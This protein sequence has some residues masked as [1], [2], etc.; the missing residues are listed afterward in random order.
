MPLLLL[1]NL[2]VMKY[3]FKPLT[4]QNRGNHKF[5]IDPLIGASVISGVGSLIGG[6]F[7]SSSTD[8]TNRANLTAVRET[9]ASNREIAEKTN[10]SN[11]EIARTTNEANIKMNQDN[12]ALQQRLQAE[13][14]Q[15][16]SVGAQLDRAR[17][18]GVNP[19]AVI[20]GSLSGNIQTSLPTSTAGHAD[21]IPNEMGQPNIAPSFLNS[22]DEKIGMLNAFTNLASTMS[23]N[24]LNKANKNKVDQETEWWTT[25]NK[26]EEESKRLGLD[27][28]HAQ[29]AKL[30]LDCDEVA[31]N[32]ENAKET[33]NQLK[34]QTSMLGHQEKM[35]A[36]DA[37]NHQDFVDNQ[38]KILK[39]QAD[40]SEDMALYTLE[41]LKADIGLVES[42]TK[43]NSVRSRLTA[44]EIELCNKNIA[45]AE[46]GRK[47]AVYETTLQQKY[48]E[49]KRW[50]EINNLRHQGRVY[51][52]TY[53]NLQYENTD[54]RRQWRQTVEGINATSSLINSVDNV[55]NTV[56][57]AR[58]SKGKP[59][60]QGQTTTRGKNTTTTTYHYK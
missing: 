44:K 24:E 54:E 1:Q 26:F 10:A 58:A 13:M 55:A 32:I 30:K 18:A 52:Q 21:M 31:Q 57:T 56:V 14:N 35:L 40:Y 27:L 60:L 7:G 3:N 50:N 16:N 59:M 51:G 36:I 20:G 33:Y 22:S 8:S 45:I 38:L 11:Q 39:T 17:Q 15:Y 53:K 19:N 12:N 43:L 6:L 4:L 49:Q 9:N 25:Q 23:Q 37:L 5:V 29:L 2:N 48:E 41:K 28:G 34:I 42:E 47:Q 46:E